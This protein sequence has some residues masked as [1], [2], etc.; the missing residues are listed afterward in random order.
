MADDDDDRVYIG[1]MAQA[2]ERRVGTIR[3]WVQSA[4]NIHDLLGHLPEGG[5]YL[6]QDL[7]PAREEAGYHRLYW[8]ADQVDGLRA[9]AEEMSRRKGWK[10][11]A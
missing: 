10:R 1:E 5:C 6:P 7:W 3:A 11:A 4:R 2:L 9:F 8:T